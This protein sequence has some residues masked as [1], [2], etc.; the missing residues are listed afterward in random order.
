[1][2]DMDPTYVSKHEN[3]ERPLTDE[4]VRKYAR[5]YKVETHEIFIKLDSE[6]DVVVG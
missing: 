1:M 2:V 6:G 4:A 3:M 5:L